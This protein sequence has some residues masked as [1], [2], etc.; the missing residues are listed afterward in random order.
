MSLV[1]TASVKEHTVLQDTDHAKTVTKFGLQA[2][3]RMR[4]ALTDDWPSV[5]PVGSR[6][7]RGDIYDAIVD[8]D[9]P[10]TTA[11]KDD[12]QQAETI[13]AL[14]EALPSL[15]IDMADDG[16]LVQSTGF[17]QSRTRYRT[18]SSVADLQK[19]LKNQAI[20]IAVG[21]RSRHNRDDPDPVFVL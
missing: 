8:G 16:Q 12:L 13:Y 2:E 3:E 5:H 9:S 14:A 10:W 11:D 20:R 19:G 7:N 17:E 4:E 15:N 21:L 18:E 1:T 6:R